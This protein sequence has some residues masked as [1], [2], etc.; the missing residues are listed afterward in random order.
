MR[1]YRC[2][3]L[4][5]ALAISLVQNFKYKQKRLLMWLHQVLNRGSYMSAIV[6]LNLLNELRKRDKMR[7]LP[8]IIQEQEC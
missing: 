1:P 4:N 8:I 5:N 3:G 6:L 2:Y 7:G